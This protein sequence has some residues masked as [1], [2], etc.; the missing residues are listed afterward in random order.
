MT[1]SKSTPPLT[2]IVPRAL[3]DHGIRDVLAAHATGRRGIHLTLS[4]DVADSTSNRLAVLA[5]AAGELIGELTAH[6]L[7]NG[8]DGFAEFWHLVNE[9]ST[10]TRAAAGRCLNEMPEHIRRQWADANIAAAERQAAQR[11]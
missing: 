2:H 4:A 10:V 3:S 11:K 7:V 9:A 8:N 6:A 1:D 5:T